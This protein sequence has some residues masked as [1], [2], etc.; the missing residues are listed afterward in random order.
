MRKL[1]V[2]VAMLAMMLLVAS[3]AMAQQ[4]E[5]LEGGVLVVTEG[6]GSLEEPPV[7]GVAAVPS[8]GGFGGAVA[9]GDT[10]S[11][12][13]PFGAF[14]TTANETVNAAGIETDVFV[15]AGSQCIDTTG[16]G[17]CP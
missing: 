14:T 16:F 6:E 8:F 11:S 12:S 7:T 10:L 9:G 15:Q 13:S 3:P 17:F 2:F 1:K 4:I 5:F